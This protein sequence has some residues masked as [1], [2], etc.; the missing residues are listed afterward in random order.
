M[1]PNP[2]HP[3]RRTMTCESIQTINVY[4]PSRVLLGDY[5]C[6]YLPSNRLTYRLE[7]VP[8][9]LFLSRLHLPCGSSNIP[10]RFPNTSRR[11]HRLPI[12]LFH[13]NLSFRELVS[14]MYLPSSLHLCVTMINIQTNKSSSRDRGGIVKSC[15]LRN[16]PSNPSR[17]LLVICSVIKE[18]CRCVNLQVP[19]RRYMYNMNSAKYNVSTM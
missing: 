15:V 16:I 10:R 11:L 12:E 13:R 17:I 3:L 7:S 1:C 4:P 18:R 6:N 14:P 9:R 19:L 5:S 8:F 2:I